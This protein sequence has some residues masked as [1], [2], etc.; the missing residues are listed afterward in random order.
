[1]ITITHLLSGTATV[2]VR[3]IYFVIKLYFFKKFFKF[4]VKNFANK[5]TLNMKKRFCSFFDKREFKKK[6]FNNFL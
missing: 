4:F 5:N 2:L 3:D 6:M 1:M